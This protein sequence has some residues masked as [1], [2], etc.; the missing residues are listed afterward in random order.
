MKGTRKYQPFLFPDSSRLIFVFVLFQFRGTR[1]S[2]RLEQANRKMSRKPRS[3]IRILMYRT[4]AIQNSATCTSPIMHRICPPKSCITFVFHFSW[5]LQPSQEK[6]KT[7][8]MQNLGGGGGEMGE[9]AGAKITCVM[10]DV[11][12]LNLIPV[13][14]LSSSSYF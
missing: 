13:S 11:K 6:L 14:W 2:Q 10:R 4:W 5:V 8:V 1:L 9:G 12:G 7:M 3:H